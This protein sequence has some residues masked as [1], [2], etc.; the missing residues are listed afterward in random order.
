MAGEFNP[1]QKVQSAG[2]E[3]GFP[4]GHL[5]RLTESEMKQ[6]DE[7]KQL[8]EER[9]LYISGPCPSHDDPTLLYACTILFSPS[10]VHEVFWVNRCRVANKTIGS[11]YLRARKWI[12]N[13]AYQQFKETEE[14]REANDIDILYKTIDIE[15]YDMARRL[16]RESE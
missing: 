14:W 1:A 6:F 10:L 5:G 11:R 3:Y 12:V 16:V 4:H 9:G 8:L 2:M 13:D 15:A 7:F